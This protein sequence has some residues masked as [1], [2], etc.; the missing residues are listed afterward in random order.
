MIYVEICVGSSCH[1]KCSPE[2]VEMLQKNIAEAGLEDDIILTG[3][4]CTG[5][6]NR[7]GV[8]LTVNDTVYPGIT[9]ESFQ[10]FW[11]N[12]ILPAVKESEV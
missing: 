5:Q 6:C 9:K 7:T 11:E 10:S 3:S 2:I 4:F 8:T 12:T 1:I